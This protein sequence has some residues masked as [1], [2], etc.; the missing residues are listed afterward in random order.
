VN[1]G[2]PYLLVEGLAFVVELVVHG[3]RSRGRLINMLTSGVGVRTK[4]C[5]HES[6]GKNIVFGCGGV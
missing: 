5:L 6:R 4:G 2:D 1:E 3:A